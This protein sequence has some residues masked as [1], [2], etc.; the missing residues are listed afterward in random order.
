MATIYLRNV[1]DELVERLQRLA[2]QAGTSVNA[3]AVQELV[4]ATKRADNP[5]LL[6]RLPDLGMS[7]ADIVADIEAARSQR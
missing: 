4:E 3:V 2:T 7:A 5:A 1:P 6:G